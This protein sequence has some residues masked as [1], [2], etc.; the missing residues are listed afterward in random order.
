MNFTFHQRPDIHAILDSADRFISIILVLPI[1]IHPEHYISIPFPILQE[2]LSVCVTI[3]H[4][5]E[6]LIKESSLPCFTTN[7]VSDSENLFADKVV[8]P[9]VNLEANVSYPPVCHSHN[10]AYSNIVIIVFPA[11]QSRLPQ[12]R[13]FHNTQYPALRI[14][15]CQ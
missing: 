14:S 1:D 10:K 2:N 15:F 8:I 7:L 11:Q 13:L 3:S 5:H 9:V 12:V 6:E 4:E